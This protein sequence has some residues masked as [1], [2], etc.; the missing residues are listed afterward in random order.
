MKKKY[1]FKSKLF[2]LIFA[3]IFSWGF[4]EI[5]IKGLFPIPLYSLFTHSTNDW[6]IRGIPVSYF[7]KEANFKVSQSL[8]YELVPNSILG[9]NNLGM[10]DKQRNIEK[11]EDT[12][13]I[14][15]LGDSTTASTD[16]T[17]IVY[18]G[19]LELLLNKNKS[20]KQFEVW[21]CAVPGYGSIQECNALLEKWIKYEPD[22]VIVGFCMNDF[23]T[24]PIVVREGDDL[25]GYFPFSEISRKINPVLLKY[26]AVYRKLLSDQLRKQKI[27]VERDVLNITQELFKKVKWELEDKNISFFVVI[28]GLPKKFAEYSVKE[29][30][31]YQK[32]KDILLSNKIDFIDTVPVF[33]INDPASLILKKN[34]E[35]HFNTKGHTLVADEIF[36]FL[37]KKYGKELF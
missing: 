10:L 34:D 3:I 26:S 4:A 21:N 8:G 36:L 15:C 13:R 17:Q 24:T 23:D 33:E 32:I 28:L 9:T 18:S 14:I 20:N 25:V 2:V 35:V 29:W 1:S 19:M 6:D 16:S 12:Y 22:I 31:Q 5:I 7:F 30:E 37:K 27:Y 11:S